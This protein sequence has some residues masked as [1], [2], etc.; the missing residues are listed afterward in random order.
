MH[1]VLMVAAA[2][3]L[4]GVLLAAEE[5][6]AKEQW[7]PPH[8]EECSLAENEHCGA[9]VQCPAELP[10]VLAG[11]GGMPKVSRN[12]HRIAMTMNVAISENAWR[13]RWQNLAGGQPTDVKVMI[14]VL[15]GDDAAA[16]G[17]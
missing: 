5:T 12:D 16:W 11:G 8:I 7:Q 10:Y 6:Q 9:D 1:R 13:V 14:R 3:A 17:K 2:G 15:C 4:A